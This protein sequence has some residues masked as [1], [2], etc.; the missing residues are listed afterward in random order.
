MIDKEN[1]NSP[2][3]SLLGEIIDDKYQIIEL[4]GAGGMGRVYKAK[5]LLMGQ[6]VAVKILS[7]ELTEKPQAMKRFAREAQAASRIDHVNVVAVRGFGICKKNKV[8]Y[9]AMQNLEGKSL[10]DVLGENG[11]LNIDRCLTIFIQI[12]AGLSEAHHKKIVHRDMKPSNILLTE[13][14]GNKDCVKVIDFGI[15]QVNTAD[16][17]T[18]LETLTAT[19]EMIGTPSYMSPEQLGGKEIDQRSDIYS[20]GCM[21]F[22][23]LTGKVPFKDDTLAAVCM[24]HL[25]AQ[26]PRLVIENGDPVLVQRL[27]A[28]IQKCLAKELPMR[29]QNIHDLKADLEQVQ[30]RLKQLES[31]RANKVLLA[32]E[33]T[34]LL[35]FRSL[36]KLRKNLFSKD[37]SSTTTRTIIVLALGLLTI[38][39]C[40]LWPIYGLG[41]CPS[42]EERAIAWLE[43]TPSIYES[44]PKKFDEA[45]KNLLDIEKKYRLLGMLHSEDGFKF[46]R[47]FGDFYLKSGVY[48]KSAQRFLYARQLLPQLNSIDIQEQAGLLL[49]SAECD[50]KRKAYDNCIKVARDALINYRKL[51]ESDYLIYSLG[52]IQ[53]LY[54]LAEANVSLAHHN[55]ATENFQNLVNILEH[56]N[57]YVVEPEKTSRYVFAAGSYF[58][59]HG[60]YALAQK[61]WKYVLLCPIN[62]KEKAI[63]NAITLNQLGL[64]E[65]KLNNYR[66][67]TDCFDRAVK[68]LSSTAGPNDLRIAK[69]LFN[70]ADVLW[71]RKDWLQWF[72]VQNHARNIWR[73]R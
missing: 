68:E 13:H 62:D 33:M 14:N 12:C 52:S 42:A 1:N 55:E 26:P 37:S 17:A 16:G 19:Q 23:T 47:M 39:G 65:T 45:E 50:F 54:Y 22:E 70:E 20:V 6:T 35:L 66:E 32:M 11:K 34:W 29:Y 2:K 38:A 57:F 24:L 72:Y 30:F 44:D 40:L 21:L 56:Q 53:S 64:V 9:L 46:Q 51:A 3:D 61:L 43:P 60:D 67:A 15:A 5:H 7:K 69:I 8:A 31:E 48:F 59:D 63:N 18:V 25:T 4:I 58:F 28:I 10:K 49:S 71:K 41:S 27:D 73:Q 36:R